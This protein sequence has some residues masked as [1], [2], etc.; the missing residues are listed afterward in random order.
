MTTLE[1]AKS[2]NDVLDHSNNDYDEDINVESSE[3]ESIEDDESEVSDEEEVLISPRT[4]NRTDSF[5]LFFRVI[6]LKDRKPKNYFVALY[7]DDKKV[8]KS[9]SIKKSTEWKDQGRF[10][11]MSNGITSI[12]VSLYQKGLLNS[13]RGT[14]TLDLKDFIEGYP[15]NRWYKLEGNKRTKGFLHLQM[16]LI[17][18]DKTLECEF[19]YPLHTFIERK[20]HDLLKLL[21]EE[22]FT[23]FTICDQE[24]RS[25]LHLAVELND[26]ESL[27]ILLKS[28][29]PK[30][31]MKLVD[32]KGNTA[33]HWACLHNAKKE[34]IELLIN[35]KFEHT[36]VNKNKETPL[37]CAAEGDN[38]P[39]IDILISKGANINSE[40]IDKNTPLAI[41]LLKHSP[42]AIKALI[43]YKSNIYKKNNRDIAVW[44]LAQRRELV[45]TEPRKVFMEELNAHDPREFIERKQYSC[46]KFALGEKIS[47]DYLKSTQF[48]ITVK[49]RTEV[50][51]LISS[52]DLSGKFSSNSLFALVKSDQGIHNEPDYSRDTIGFGNI[53]PLR[54]TLHPG[55]FYNV[56]PIVKSESYEGKY[57]LLVLHKED[58][59][60]KIS[61][62]QPWNYE[63][64]LEGEWN[65]KTAGGGRH[66][67][68]WVDNPQYELILPEKDKVRFLVYLS[69]EK[70]DPEFRIPKDGELRKIPY[71]FNIGFI[72][73]DKSGKPVDQTEKFI[74]ARGVHKEFVLNCS[75]SNR[76]KIIPAT[77][78]PGEESV[79]TLK[80][81]CD[82]PFKLV[83]KR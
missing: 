4:A 57:N 5:K 3:T 68:S 80:V 45:N 55:Y 70:N 29:D 16:M 77:W 40:D 32:K 12:K 62:L 9:K 75:E 65:K 74:N 14:I 7:F 59:D 15:Y 30:V 37:H 58:D 73:L 22:Q 19:S 13:P 47:V 36:D 41:A 33:L 18:P 6:E 79:F 21:V 17:A 60:C 54:I 51:I 48:T 56:I 76:W 44:E 69:Q 50:V 63:V 64:A 81:F 28:M 24:G 8:Y 49:K 39:A 27:N 67:S 46:K 38:V 23:N 26:L 1:D 78:N 34:I 72:I 20:R 61:E 35:S 25:A 2:Y 66:N 71:R 42:N 11:P 31:P 83:K 53:N 10:L 43:R 52:P 82:E